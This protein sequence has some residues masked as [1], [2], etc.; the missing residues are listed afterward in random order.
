MKKY[1]IVVLF[2]GLLFSCSSND[3]KAAATPALPLT[4]QTLANVAYGTDP[5][6]KM[7]VYLPANRTTNTKVV[8]VIHGGAWVEGDKADMAGVAAIVHE[9]FPDYAVVNINYRLA[10][11]SSPAFPKQTE[12]LRK[13]IN[14]L[15]DSNYTISDDYALVGASAGAHIAMLYSY[16]YDTAHEV[17]VVCNIVGPA[18]FSDPAYVTHPLYSF[19]AQA[20]LGTPNVTEQMIA[21]VSPINHIT[22]QSPPTITFYGGVDPLIPSSQ[23]PRLKAALDAAGVYNEFYF[24]PEG[25]HANWDQVTFDD[26]YARFTAFFNAKFR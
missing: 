23:G 1:H 19:A 6:Q 10:T 12:D 15:K 22:A 25:G 26:V 8:I 13:V 11:Q 4:E 7:D 17:K 5:Q 9:R 21:D 14:F 20:L 18:D 16:K 2:L 24:Y 3:D